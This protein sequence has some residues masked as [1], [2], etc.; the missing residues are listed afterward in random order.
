MRSRLKAWKPSTLFD[1]GEEVA[2]HPGWRFMFS[3]TEDIAKRDIIFEPSELPGWDKINDKLAQL[4]MLT[5]Q[6]APE[7][8][9]LYAWHI[10][11]AA[12]RRIAMEDNLPM[13]QMPTLSLINNLYTFGEIP[14]DHFSAL[15]AT[16]PTRNQLAQGKNA[17][18]DSKQLQAFV[19]ALKITITEYLAYREEKRLRYLFKAQELA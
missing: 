10:C 1:L 2:E 19:N 14:L 18:V 9:L 8:T 11:E 15:K 5:R 17:H 16:L 6:Q 7:P 3:T 13:E 12:L 4:G